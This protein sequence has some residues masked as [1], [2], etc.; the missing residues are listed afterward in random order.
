M[1]DLTLA[2]QTACIWEATA[3]KP[4]NVN[5]FAD[6]ADVTYLDMLLSAAAIA[7]ALGDAAQQGVG[8]TMVECVCATRAAVRTNT[9]LGIILLLV[10]LACASR[11]FYHPAGMNVLLSRLKVRETKEV[12]EAIQIAR[13]GGMGK[14]AEQDIAQEPTLPLQ[15]VMALAADRDLVARQYANGFVEVF[16]VGVSALEAGIEKIG[17]LEG[18]IVWTHL[19]LLARYPDSL[20]ARK[21]GPEEAQ[22]ASAR[23]GKV[24]EAGWPGEPAGRAALT[25][26][27]AWLRAVDHQRNPGTTADLVTA[28]LFVALRM[29]TIT[30]PS[31]LPWSTGDL[32]A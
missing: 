20:I 27:D 32:Y 19:Q 26:F 10:P 12:Y 30:L 28:S 1:A 24:L 2:V 31:S 11:S 14:V 8:K 13:P 29:G 16:D 18:A 4:G 5:R 17:S 15:E 6:F 21:R 7:P 23:A 3:R 25:E 9:N 22:E